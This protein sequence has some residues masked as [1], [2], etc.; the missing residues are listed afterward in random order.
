MPE[1]NAENEVPMGTDIAITDSELWLIQEAIEMADPAPDGPFTTSL[2][3]KNALAEIVAARSPRQ[4][5]RVFTADEVIE[6]ANETSD[7]LG[8]LCRLDFIDR[9]RH[10]ATNVTPHEGGTDG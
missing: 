8:N 6:I 1:Q 2:A 4:R 10:E 7:S 5:P 9:I 3:I